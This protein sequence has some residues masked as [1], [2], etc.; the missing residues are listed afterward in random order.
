MAFVS[1]YRTTI[2]DAAWEV[3]PEAYAKA[4][5]SGRYPAHARQVFYAARG[6]I[7]R[8]VTEADA[9]DSNYFTQSLLPEYMR[10]HPETGTWDVVFDARGHLTEPHTGIVV[11]LGT[12]DV[13]EYL[14]STTDQIEPLAVPRFAEGHLPTRGPTNRYSAILFI[15]K[16]GFLPLFRQVQLAERYDIAI[17]STKGMSVTAARQLVDTLCTREGVPL[18]VVRDFDKAGF[19]IPYSLKSDT[20]RYTFTHAIRVVDL[21]LRLTDVEEWGLES[22]PVYY[23]SYPEQLL[24]NRGA[25]ED[26]IEF[27]C[28]YDRYGQRVELNA[29]TSENLIKWIEQKLAE[30]GVKKVIPDAE[31][32]E[33]AYRRA[34]AIEYTNRE[35]SRIGDEAAKVAAAARVP[36]DLGDRVAAAFRKHPELPW[37]R[38]V[39]DIAARK[40]KK[41]QERHPEEAS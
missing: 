37:D 18:P 12:L 17:M 19:S 35:L 41:S 21:G 29:F 6:P 38:V 15:E 27:L 10:E 31:T 7:L 22:E 11:P 28:G 40:C 16:E 36:N 13:R 26:E 5:S 25:T 20:D 8:L 39:A 1:S 4:S 9:L 33:V 34:V 24:R 30:N 32:L 3:M 2:K 14:R 23:K